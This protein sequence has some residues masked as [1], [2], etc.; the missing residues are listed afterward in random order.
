MFLVSEFG[1]SPPYFCEYI[2]PAGTLEGGI[3]LLFM[4]QS[5]RGSIGYLFLWKVFLLIVI[6]VASILIYRPFCRYLCPLGAFY[7]LFNKVSFYKYDVDK[8][9]CTNCRACV[10]KCKINIE[11][12]KNPN[13]TECIR[14]GECEKICPT[15]AI[16]KGINLKNVVTDSEQ[17]LK[18]GIS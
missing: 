5:L 17:Q 11:V 6:L 13:S 10:H 8:E 16:K 15:K 4:N 3:P 12:Y 9:K 14:C 18:K 1:I 7:S 2:C